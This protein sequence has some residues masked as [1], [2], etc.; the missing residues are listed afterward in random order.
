MIAH[1][2]REQLTMA[3]VA[4]K[5]A[6]RN[7]ST[8][9]WHSCNNFMTLAG[10]RLSDQAHKRCLTKRAAANYNFYIY[11]YICP[12]TA[13]GFSGFVIDYYIY[14]FAGII[15]RGYSWMFEFRLKPLWLQSF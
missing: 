15:S 2:L 9:F 6:D 3:C 7:P 13:F 10:E 8:I 1:V 4:K 14:I 12:Q 11:I 5:W